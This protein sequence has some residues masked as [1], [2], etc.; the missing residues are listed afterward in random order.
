MLVNGRVI[1][2][3]L[4]RQG[5]GKGG[6]AED[7]GIVGVSIQHTMTTARC[8]IRT[9][10][11]KVHATDATRRQK[12]TEMQEYSDSSYKELLLNVL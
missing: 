3:L 4:I 8:R 1:C 11:C 6:G 5:G 12:L 7:K 10:P 9:A 2:Q